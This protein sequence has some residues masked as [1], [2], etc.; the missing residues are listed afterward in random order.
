MS[1]E[2]NRFGIDL[3]ESRP[4]EEIVNTLYEIFD[5]LELSIG[6]FFV[7]EK[8]HPRSHKL[9][10][11]WRE[12]LRKLYD[13]AS[14]SWQPYQDPNGLQIPVFDVFTTI[15]EDFFI[16]VIVKPT[17]MTNRMKTPEYLKLLRERDAILEQTKDPKTDDYE[18]R[19]ELTKKQHEL[20]KVL[21]GMD[22][23]LLYG[24]FIDRKARLE[25]LYSY[26]NPEGTEIYTSIHPPTEG[27][28]LPRKYP[29]WDELNPEYRSEVT[30]KLQALNE[31][32]DRIMVM[33]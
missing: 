29:Y 1:E 3:V 31:Q 16:R 4:S 2:E 11:G 12:G 27:I 17:K 9:K 6:G 25:R 15:G 24:P 32:L 21:W 14:D 5:K 28:L 10:K 26:K 33:V 13:V 23:T 20:S 18:R 8:E 19:K 7:G 22:K 30:Q